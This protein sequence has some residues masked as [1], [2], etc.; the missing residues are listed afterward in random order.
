MPRK[1][2]G[3]YQF[4]KRRQSIRYCPS[5]RMHTKWN[6]NKVIGHAVCMDCG[7]SYFVGGYWNKVLKNE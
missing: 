4:L 2:K 3:R 5:C 7:V 1:R 6:Y